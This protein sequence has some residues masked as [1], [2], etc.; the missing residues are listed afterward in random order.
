MSIDILQS[1]YNKNTPGFGIKLRNLPADFE[2]ISASINNKDWYEMK[3]DRINSSYSETIMFSNLVSG[4][5]YTVKVKIISNSKEEI[6]TKD[7]IALKQKTHSNMIKKDLL[8]KW[9]PER[10]S[11]M[12]NEIEWNNSG[13]AARK[14]H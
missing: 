13:G 4:D 5:E 2:Y 3:R 7:F 1:Y 11:I 14:W 6:I 9:F 12:L 8:E 10:N